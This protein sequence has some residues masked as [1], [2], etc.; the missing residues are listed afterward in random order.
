MLTEQYP[1]L[2]AVLMIITFAL[3]S[4]LHRHLSEARALRKEM[5]RLKP[6]QDAWQA[7]EDEWRK[8][9]RARRY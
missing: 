1:T 7:R 6:A 2:C 4:A 5:Q 3:L 8:L 9:E